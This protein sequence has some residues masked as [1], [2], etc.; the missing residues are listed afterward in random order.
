MNAKRCTNDVRRTGTRWEFASMLITL[1]WSTFRMAV[2]WDSI[3]LVETSCRLEIGQATHRSE[4]RHLCS[5][6]W[7]DF[8]FKLSL[9]HIL[10]TERTNM[11]GTSIKIAIHAYLLSNHFYKRCWILLIC[12]NKCY[13]YYYSEF[14][15][16]WQ[17]YFPNSIA[18]VAT[19]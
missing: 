15:F 12:W 9:V 18:L 1:W 3:H 6:S 10:L 7:L 8:F 4:R 14:W 11:I 16:R 17:K 19:I 13:M 2:L 5:Y